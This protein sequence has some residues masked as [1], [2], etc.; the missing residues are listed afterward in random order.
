MTGYANLLGEGRGGGGETR[1][2]MDI[3]KCWTP[4]TITGMGTSSGK[5]ISEIMW[6]DKRILMI[7]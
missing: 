6:V 2:I 4:E 5:T 3:W 7:G 1:C